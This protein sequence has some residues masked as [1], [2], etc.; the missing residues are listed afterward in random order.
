M[1]N[2]LHLTGFAIFIENYLRGIASGMFSIFCDTFDVCQHWLQKKQSMRGIWTIFLSV[3]V[4][5]FHIIGANVIHL[6]HIPV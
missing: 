3:E 1:H 5:L 6:A 4:M 2:L